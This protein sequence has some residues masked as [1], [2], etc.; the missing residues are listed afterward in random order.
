[1]TRA[2]SDSARRDLA[3]GA[4]D[5]GA[6]RRGHGGV[7]AVR[8]A[9]QSRRTARRHR[10]PDHAGARPDAGDPGARHRSVHRRESRA[11]RHAG[12]AVQPRAIPARASCRCCCSR[13]APAR[14]LGALNGLLV[15]KLRLPPIVVTL[16]TM[17]VYRGVIYLLSRRRLGQRE[18]DVAA[19]SSAFPRAELL[20]LTVLSWL[21]IVVAAAVRASRCATRASGATCMRPAAIPRQQRTPASMPGACN[22]SRTRSAARSRACAAICGWRDSRWRTPTSRSASSCR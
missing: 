15:W 13:S 7:S 18:R 20:G 2:L 14:L 8:G 17:S 10:H 22:S 11:V 19:A 6:V 21:A 12:R 3:L 9:A 5:A 16:G 4:L 1:M